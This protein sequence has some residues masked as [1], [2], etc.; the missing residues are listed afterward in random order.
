M[1]LTAKV[2]GGVGTKFLLNQSSW[3]VNSDANAKI[4]F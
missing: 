3:K 2:R 4:K 1:N